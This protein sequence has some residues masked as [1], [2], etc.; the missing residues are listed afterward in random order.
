M[1]LARYLYIMFFLFSAMS[2]GQLSDFNFNV[3]AIDETCNNN[4][5]LQMT[6][7]NTSPGAEIIYQLYLAPDFANDIGAT[8]TSGF[9]GLAAGTYR[10]VATQAANGTSNSKQVDKTINDL[11]QV[12]D[13]EIDDTTATDCDTTATL[14][15][16]VL[17]GNPTLYEI[18]DGPEIRPVQTSNQ[19]SG[20]A[21]GTYTIRVFDDCGDALS[22]AY[23]FFLGNNDLSISAPILP[24]V[25]SSCTSVEITNQVSSVS[26]AP[27][28]Y[29]L[30]IEYTIFAP[31]G[32]VAQNFTQ[33]LT[34]G[35][36]DVLELTQTIDLFGNQLFSIKIEITD[37]C[38]RTFIEDFE[39]DPNPKLSFLSHEADCG[40]LF[41]EIV[42]TNYFPPFTLNFTEPVEFNPTTFN[43]NY[44]GP[45]N[46]D[47]IF[48][49]DLENPVPF[50]N[51][52][53]S[54]QDACGRTKNLSF[55]LTKKLVKPAVTTSNLGCASE[56]G[57]VRIQIPGREIVSIFITEAPVAYSP[58]LPSNV[59]TFV[60][61]EGM[62]INNNLPIGVY[63]FTIV[64]SCGDEYE[65]EV[66]VPAFV[67]GPLVADTKPNCNAISGGVKLTTTN[68]KLVTVHIVTAPPT[69]MQSLP[70]DISF[71]IN[72]GGI[73]YMTDL[74]AG[75][76]SF[77]AVDACGFALDASIEVNGYN[78]N[79]NGF[80][81]N[82][83]CGSFDI[84][85]EDTDESVTG[86]TYWLQK[87][88]P[89]TNTWGHPTTG[90]TFT[91][92]SIPNATTG[93]GLANLNT[94]LNV[95][96]TGDFRIIKVF[97]TYNNGSAG[98]KCTD[99]Y[100]EFTI[101][102]ELVI[103]GAYNLNCND[104]GA[105]ND[106]VLDVFGVAPFQFKITSPIVVDNG[107]SAA[108]YDLP[109]GVFNFQVM[110]DCG[111]IKN[112]T[113]EV[114]TLLPLAR[115]NKPQSMLV[116]RNDG[117]QFGI[118]PLVDQKAQILGVQNPN[119]YN[120]TFH[121]SQEAADSGQNPLPDGYTNISNPQTIFARVQ[122]KVI[123]GCYA[124]TSFNIFAGITP[125]LDPVGDFFICEGYNRMLTAQAGFSGYL[126][127]TGETTQSIIISE[128]GTYTV[129]VQNVYEDISCTNSIDYVVTASAKAQIEVINTSDWSSESNAAEIIVTGIGDYT[130]S[131]DGINFQTSNTFSELR[132]GLY[133]V[134]VKDENGCGIAEE[135]FVLINYPKFFTPNGDGYNDYWNISL[136]SYEP[137]MNVD[138]FDRFGKFI[139]KLK[140]GELGWDGTYNGNPMP[141][142]DY[143]FV[144]TRED[145]TVHRE[146]FSLKR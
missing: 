127:S 38:N 67:F 60:D 61:A 131:L 58:T 112:T 5:S 48:F 66:S 98:G 26:N 125:V 4:G 134:Y 47:T 117:V 140:G 19:F 59:M 132:S 107:P 18:F 12:L 9:S 95:F 32:T 6:V 100:V 97:E 86:K 87:F 94:L 37:N 126:W 21:S 1:F 28:L 122:H 3:V 40:E 114:G 90:A 35:P 135:I 34:S 52:K 93:K 71:N 49:G 124:T 101:A 63:N 104:I 27:I 129:T 84:T 7:S 123:L 43:P 25:Y 74:P 138:V 121:L 106:I 2:Y 72:A 130:Y 62:F 8:A 111:N 120:V 143:W 30:T 76:Y 109:V 39:I 146:H 41:F 79:S 115:A 119:S 78:S 50:G 108:F 16:N 46:D 36:E 83:K 105:S 56:F 99:L 133:T 14:V 11:K 81:L 44:P 17:S 113:V 70:Y 20:L 68:G 139:I 144:V 42:I 64:D 91:P 13:Y 53:V 116:C 29:P 57:K 65:K 54:A 24:S 45:Y 73:L 145:G 80:L 69:F 110:D 103:V 22:K 31:D 89:A 77:E 55:S 10:I 15:V 142:T 96:Y 118:F 85:I 33:N 102:S 88:F 141:S 82:R 23:T 51:Y 128:A 137:N 92:G 75:M 136:S